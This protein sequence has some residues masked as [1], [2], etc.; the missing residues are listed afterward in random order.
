MRNAASAILIFVASAFVGGD[1]IVA[2]T[3]QCDPSKVMTAE[4]CAKCHVNEVAIWKKTPHST[5]FQELSR[6]PRAKEICKNLGLRSVKRS[7]VCINCHYT[8]KE[9]DGRNKA[10]SG[11]SCESCHGAAR[12]WLTAHND[13]GGPTATKESETSTDKNRR[14]QDCLELG[15]NN[16][17]DLYSIAMNCL[18]CHTVPNEELVNVGGH[19]CGTRDFEL[20]AWSQGMMRHNFLRGQNVENVE[21]PLERLR[22]MYLVGLIADLEYSTRATAVATKKSDYGLTVAQRAVNKALKLFEIQRQLNHA[23]IDTILK[24]FAAAELK[25]N[26]A[27][28]LNSIADDIQKIGRRFAREADGAELTVIDKWL[29]ERSEF[30]WNP[31]RMKDQ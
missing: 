29:P 24:K 20:V 13:Y 10:V 28:Q 19:V 9:V 23:D 17:R 25:V 4:A 11:V 26:N 7:D 5:T 1:C 16:T 15:M 21:S 2:Q 14:L 8:L 6:R 12:D 3:V 31:S 27:A 22:V 30:K 18:N